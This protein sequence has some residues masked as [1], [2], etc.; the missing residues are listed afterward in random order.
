[1][2]RLILSKPTLAAIAIAMAA[3]ELASD[4]TTHASSPATTPLVPD[5]VCRHCPSKAAEISSHL[6]KLADASVETNAQI[7]WSISNRSDLGYRRSEEVAPSLGL[8]SRGTQVFYVQEL[9]NQRG[10][11]TPMDG[12]LDA[13]TYRAL[14]QFQSAYGLDSSGII[15]TQTM[16]A[17]QN[18]DQPPP[19]PEP[20][21][22]PIPSAQLIHWGDRGPAVK[23]VQRLLVYQGYGLEIDGV[24]GAETRQAV[25]QFQIVQQLEPDGIVGPVTMQ[26][27]L[28]M[29][30]L[31][32]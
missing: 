6:F 24:F 2:S 29:P 32:I 5:S 25:T 11:S 3:T 18:S 19:T 26:V 22:D 20:E 15:E 21:P 4:D 1:M 28:T 16:T 9:L 30:H 27:L 23:Q 31:E 14:V 10:F 8:G 12:L 17:L 7:R 13:K